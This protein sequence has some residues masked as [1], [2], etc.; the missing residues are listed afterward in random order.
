MPQSVTRRTIQ[1]MSSF[2][3]KKT[4]G[5]GGGGA[6]G[7][8]ASTA[9]VA[10]KPRPK[11]SLFGAVSEHTPPIH[12][13]SKPVTGY[14]PLLVTSA[15]EPPRIIPQP[16]SE[17]HYDPNLAYQACSQPPSNP[18][19]LESMAQT[20]GLD[21]AAMRQLLGRKGRGRNNIPDISQIATFDV[22]TEYASNTLLARSEEAQRAASVNPVR[23][24]APGK[25]HLT[26]LLNAAQ[27]QKGSLEEAFA[28]GKRNR[29]E[30]GGK[31]GW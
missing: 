9:L 5:S 30:A 13:S 23:S 16:S 20:I 21:D 17:A 24:I 2:R 19:S 10:E 15:L 12:S 4:P 22:N 11:V 3:K 6:G 18:N 14:K 29:R 25:H 28:E 26:Q 7:S 1:P 27:Q 8:G 31:Y